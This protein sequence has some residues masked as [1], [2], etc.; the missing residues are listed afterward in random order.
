V[1]QSLVGNSNEVNVRRRVVDTTYMRVTVR[2]MLPP[3]YEVAPGVQCV[4]LSAL[5]NFRNR[6]DRY[7]I[8]RACKTAMDGR[9]FVTVVAPH[10]IG[11]PD[12]D[13]TTRCVAAQSG[14][15]TT[16]LAAGRQNEG[17]H[18]GAIRAIAEATP[19]TICSNGLWP[20]ADCFA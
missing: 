13:Q 11:G 4:A 2:S 8:V 17:R 15:H 14:D 3:P 18:Q 6:F 19:S 16:R 1:V 5:L 20:A 10:Q 12:L 9:V 7:T